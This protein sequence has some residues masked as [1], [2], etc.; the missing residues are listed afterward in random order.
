MSHSS[1][2]PPI[3]R[4]VGHIIL[5]TPI[6]NAKTSDDYIGL[7]L[8]RYQFE[9]YNIAQDLTI[10]RHVIPQKYT[11]FDLS[12]FKPLM[13][14]TEALNKV[15]NAD[16]R[17]GLQLGM[18]D[19]LPLYY[20]YGHYDSGEEGKRILREMNQILIQEPVLNSIAF[21][22]ERLVKP[23]AKGKDCR[24]TDL[25]ILVDQGFEFFRFWVASQGKW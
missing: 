21:D 12:K 17:F 9:L 25:Q 24:E 7:S 19:K 20:G 3:A 2:Y 14:Y 11:D 8:T 18:I 10:P 1:K 15:R 23:F 6:V 5:N 13:R 22:T 16:T 4:A